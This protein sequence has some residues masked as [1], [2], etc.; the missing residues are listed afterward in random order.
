MSTRVHELAKELGLK[1]QELLDRIVGW[2]L[3]IKPSIFAGLLPDQVDRIKGL[4]TGPA[5]PVTAA[6]VAQPS[7]RSSTPPPETPAISPTAPVAKRPAPQAPVAAEPAPT[8]APAPVARNPCRRPPPPPLRALDRRPRWL[9]LRPRSSLEA[10][11]PTPVAADPGLRWLRAPTPVAATAP[12]SA[13]VAKAPLSGPPRPG[14]GLT[15]PP[16]EVAWEPA[17]VRFP[18]IRR[19]AGVATRGANPQPPPMT[20]PPMPAQGATQDRSPGTSG[21]TRRL[22]RSA[23]AERLHLAGRRPDA[24]GSA[25]TAP[26]GSRPVRPGQSLERR[27]K[28]R[29]SVARR[30]CQSALADRWPQGAPQMPLLVAPTDPAPA[31]APRP[32]RASVPDRKFTPDE[33]RRMMQSGQ[34]GGDRRGSRPLLAPA[35]ARSPQQRPGGP[36]GQRPVSGAPPAPGQQQMRGPGATRWP[37]RTWR[38][39]AGFAVPGLG[40][41]APPPLVQPPIDDEEEK[42]KAA[43]RIGSPADRA[44]RRAKRNERANERRISSPQPASA[45]T[46]EAEDDGRGRR[47]SRKGQKVGRGKL[48]PVRK[49]HAEI[50]TPITVRSL[51]EAIGIRANELIRKMMNSMGQIDHHQRLARRRGRANARP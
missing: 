19:I 12:A 9:L 29:G 7:A 47:G 44:G 27:P 13:P 26:P 23:Q 41:V 43:G 25:A 37:R 16:R 35:V 11:V 36:W 40:T 6:P 21:P 1:S 2:G 15:A 3:E 31:R 28:R 14:G 46:G 34:I 51:S 42:K 4:M 49:S 38:S 48:A 10:T 20:R 32:G 22:P 30:R 39:R 8:A 33:M 50:E 24:H 18:G 17:P 5:E 45:L